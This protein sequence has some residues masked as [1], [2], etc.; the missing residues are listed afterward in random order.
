MHV[1]CDDACASMYICV[2]CGG[3]WCLAYG[4][5]REGRPATTTVFK[6]AL[7]SRALEFREE[8]E[9]KH[10]QK[11]RRRSGRSRAGASREVELWRCRSTYG[12]E[13][14]R[15]GRTAKWD[16]KTGTEMA[17]DGNGMVTVQ[18]HYKQG[19]ARR[20]DYHRLLT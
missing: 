2:W 4:A 7:H 17:C 12:D 20:V 14:G 1:V 15:D 3:D 5:W 18:W 11:R 19:K 16:T 9:E 6:N 13:A 10:T 8:E